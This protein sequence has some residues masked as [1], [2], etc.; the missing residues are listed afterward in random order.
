VG[1][2]QINVDKTSLNFYFPRV[3]DITLS[4]KDGCSILFPSNVK[5][6][7]MRDMA[8]RANFVE[9]T[10][11]D[12]SIDVTRSL[13]VEAQKLVAGIPDILLKG[14]NIVVQASKLGIALS[15]FTVKAGTV[16]I[17][18]SDGI[19][20]SSVKKNITLTSPAGIAIAAKNKKEKAPPTGV[21]IKG[22]T[23]IDMDA[24]LIKVGGFMESAVLGTEFMMQWTT[25]LTI[26]MAGADTLAGVSVGPLAAFQPGFQTIS[27]SIAG[28]L[29]PKAN[30][31][32]SKKVMVG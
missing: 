12:L 22:D 32:I 17:T 15:D 14:T 18:G 25:L 27:K 20:L 6:I 13:T 11:S 10:F 21:V 23:L 30:K 7:S 19:G 2:A 29:L 5:D 3:C 9:T 24:Q 4:A 28:Q 31:F 26:L 8:L 1:Q 16:D